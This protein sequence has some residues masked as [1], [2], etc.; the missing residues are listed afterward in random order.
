MR[1]HLV[2]PI[3]MSL[4]AVLSATLQHP[5]RAA[6]ATSV[7]GEKA[8]TLLL[9]AGKHDRGDVPVSVLVDAESADSLRPF[10]RHLTGLF[11]VEVLLS[12]DQDSYKRLAD[13]LGLKHSVCRRHINQNVAKLIADLGELALKTKD[14]PPPGVQRTVD[15]FLAD[16]EYVQWVVALRPTDGAEQLGKL[17]QSYQ[18]APPPA[19]GEKATFWYRF[20][21]ALLR[22]YDNLVT[23]HLRPALETPA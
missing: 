17:L 12:D 22:W 18:A 13:E 19:K 2:T 4:I 5:L 8:I 14:P 1:I 6:E 3:V 11:E 15:E 20:C 7:N 16:L 10:L 9:H 23:H 21:L